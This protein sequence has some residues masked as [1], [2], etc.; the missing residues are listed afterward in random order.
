[1]SSSVVSGSSICWNA[2]DGLTRFGFGSTGFDLL[3][4]MFHLYQAQPPQPQVDVG[5]GQPSSFTRGNYSR[6]LILHPALRPFNILLAGKIPARYA[7]RVAF[8]NQKPRSE[9]K[10]YPRLWWEA[11]GK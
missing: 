1:M 2:A 3:L 9:G 8:L 7:V 10:D 11:A 5:C 4:A 6:V